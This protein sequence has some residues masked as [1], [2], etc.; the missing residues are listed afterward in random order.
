M[1]L[2]S[3][4]QENPL[5]VKDSTPAAFEAFL[6]FI[7]TGTTTITE[8]DVFPLLYL[9]KKYMVGSLVKAVMNHLEEGITSESVGQI[10]LAGQNF[11][12]DAPPKDSVEA[13][14]EALLQSDEFLQL[15]K[16]TVQALIQRELPVEEKLIY[17]KAVA[18]AKA[19][20]AR[21]GFLHL[22]IKR[23]GFFQRDISDIQF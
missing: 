5:V 3:V 15:R 8:V 22:P 1:F 14:G 20:C 19:E 18:W 21:C 4:P 23:K 11:L 16:D 7:Y 2:G 13:H 6:R 9:G 10:V 12:D 17:D